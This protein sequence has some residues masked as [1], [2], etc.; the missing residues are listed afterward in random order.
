MPLNT[1]R[2]D[3]LF[4]GYCKTTNIFIVIAKIKLVLTFNANAN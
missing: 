3:T 2:Y 1:I 4:C